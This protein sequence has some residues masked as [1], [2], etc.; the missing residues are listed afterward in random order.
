MRG[1]AL[2]VLLLLAAGT[3]QAAD[4]PNPYLSQARVLYLGLE[5]E[6]CVERL[7]QAAQWR[8]TPEEQV[9][10]EIYAGLCRFDLRQEKSAAEHFR[11][12]LRLNPDAKLPSDASPPIRELFDSV[13]AQMPRVA[14]EPSHPPPPPPKVNLTPPPP[15]PPAAG[16][17]L[18]PTPTAHRNIVVPISLEA[19][20]LAVAATALV[21]GLEAKRLE[22]ESNQARKE[23]D[24]FNLGNASRRDA[25]ISN[26]GT[27]VAAALGV[28]AIL[29]YF[30]PP[31]EP[32]KPQ[33]VTP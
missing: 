9:E 22:T 3:A 21:F 28:G 31:A 25:L 26:V 27:G 4:R 7:Q 33:A 17:D 20:A 24:A 6:K 10:I 15:R 13:A 2:L 18:P 8:S 16:F 30:L 12:A 14:P 19:A 5:Y 32:Q 1:R 23:I 29:S 11:M